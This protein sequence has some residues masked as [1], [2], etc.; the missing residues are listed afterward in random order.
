MVANIPFLVDSR[1]LPRGGPLT[2][3]TA[4]LEHSG[5][6]P[7]VVLARL[8]RLNNERRGHKVALRRFLPYNAQWS[9][10]QAIPERPAEV[11][12]PKGGEDLVL[13]WARPGDD[14]SFV[15]VLVEKTD[16]ADALE[17]AKGRAR[18]EDLLGKVRISVSLARARSIDMTASMTAASTQMA[19]CPRTRF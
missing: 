14:L 6:Q 8:R 15:A 11:S 7:P 2:G 1:Y 19:T 9:V 5:G 13:E 4:S 16:L 10:A 12:T 18:R 17:L 3:T